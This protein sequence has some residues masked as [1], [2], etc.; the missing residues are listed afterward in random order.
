MPMKWFKLG[1]ALVLVAATATAIVLALLPKPVPVETATVEQGPLRV[2]IDEDGRTRVQDRYVITT[3]LTGNL[4]RIEL[5]PGAAVDEGKVVARIEPI[6][7]PLLDARAK[8]ELHARVLASEASLRGASA[9]IARAQG[10]ASFATRQAERLRTLARTGGASAEE[11]ETAELE[12]TSAA[13]ERE[14]AKF[15]T[16]VARH[17]LEM[18]KAALERSTESSTEQFEIRSPIVGSVLRILRES[19]G[20]VVAG[21]ALMEVADPRALEIVVDVLTADAVEITP[22]DRVEIDRWGGAGSLAGHVRLVEPSAFTKV[23]SLGVEEQRVNVI[24]ALDEDYARW[25]ALGDGYAVEAGIVIWE[26]AAAIQVPTSAL[27]RG[28]QGWLVFV[29]EG[30]VART[31]PVSLGRRGARAVQIR[32]GVEPGEVLVVHPSDRVRDGVAIER[33]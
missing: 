6:P 31:R 11:L 30:D 21:E 17:E 19:E 1:L 18:A 15:A 14:S 8:S 33:L 10:R 4:G 3:P 22:G 32:E 27:V 29:V 12:A 23:S 26:D 25:K 28:S 16:S 20:V 13:K 7:P 5:E 2:T 9:S 24:I